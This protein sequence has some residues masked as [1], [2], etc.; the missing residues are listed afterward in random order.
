[1]DRRKLLISGA[2]ALADFAV[3]R[4]QVVSTGNHRKIFTAAGPIPAIL[5]FA[6]STVD[7]VYTATLPNHSAGGMVAV[8][9]SFQLGTPTIANTAGYTWTLAGSNTTANSGYTQYIW[10]APKTVDASSDT[11]TVTNGAASHGGIV[12]ADISNVSSVDATASASASGFGTITTG[13]FA[14]TGPND[15]VLSIGR[16]QGGGSVGA[17]ATS[18]TAGGTGG[19]WGVE[20][21]D[22]AQYQQITGTPANAEMGANSAWDIL[23]VAL[24]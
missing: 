9:G 4:G 14:V 15:M 24:K 20:A 7:G 17:G 23:A 3:L 10:T 11:V 8:L 16:L 22:L 2:A 1:M 19:F 5:Q 12:F 13:P 6:L 18:F 21:Y